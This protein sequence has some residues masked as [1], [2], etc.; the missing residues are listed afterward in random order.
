MNFNCY[1]LPLVTYVISVSAFLYYNPIIEWAIGTIIETHLLKS[2]T[3][4][5]WRL[6]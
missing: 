1:F 3:S 5:F 4:Y 6:L 2:A